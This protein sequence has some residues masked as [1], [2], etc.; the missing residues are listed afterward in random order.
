MF[1]PH[2][3]C[4]SIHAVQKG[5]KA[6]WFPR[7]GLGDFSQ[8]CLVGISLHTCKYWRWAPLQP[9]FVDFVDL[10]IFLSH[11]SRPF[12]VNHVHHSLIGLLVTPFLPCHSLFNFGLICATSEKGK[13]TAWQKGWTKLFL[14]NW[15]LRA[16]DQKTTCFFNVC[17]PQ[18]FWL[19]YTSTL[20]QKDECWW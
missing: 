19:L 11:H 18:I 8:W 13:L 17:R 12:A 16:R 9:Y 4:T 3:A 20:T 15:R 10:V 2:A 7:K 14:L 6:C 1:I 5:T